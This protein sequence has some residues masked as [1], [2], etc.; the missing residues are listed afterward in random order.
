[1]AILLPNMPEYGFLLAACTVVGCPAT[2]VNP[3]YTPHEIA[4]QIKMSKAKKIVTN[5]TFLDKVKEATSQFPG[6]LKIED[7]RKDQFPPIFRYFL[8]F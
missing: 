7:D 6:N 8:P 4:R 1:M 5:S 3:V 2:T